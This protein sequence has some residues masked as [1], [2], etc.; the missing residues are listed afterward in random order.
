[1]PL[2]QEP[3]PSPLHE[4]ELLNRV[5]DAERLRA[6]RWISLLRLLASTLFWGIHLVLGLGFDKLRSATR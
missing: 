1:M 2:P 3:A 4:K 6:T 5:L